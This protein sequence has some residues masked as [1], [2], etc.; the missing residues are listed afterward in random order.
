[1]G[2]NQGVRTGYPDSPGKLLLIGGGGMFTFA[3]KENLLS[4]TLKPNEFHSSVVTDV[5][6]VLCAWV[7]VANC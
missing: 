5:C 7:M 4:L 6:T 3:V 1:V 2:R